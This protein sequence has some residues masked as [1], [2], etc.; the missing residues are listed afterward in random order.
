MNENP[1]K[2][3]VAKE[4]SQ[5]AGIGHT[6]A[7]QIKRGTR[8]LPVEYCPAVSRHFGIPLETLR[9]DKADFFRQMKDA[10]Q[11]SIQ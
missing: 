5:C 11:G 3:V 7:N 4:L 6:F 8:K 10:V 9:P 2:D 1:L